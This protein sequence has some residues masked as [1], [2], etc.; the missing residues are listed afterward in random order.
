LEEELDGL[1][2]EFSRSG[3]GKQQSMRSNIL[4]KEERLQTLLKQYEQFVKNVRN[5]ELK[6]L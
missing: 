1:R 3:T 6:K 2:L 4:S 5:F